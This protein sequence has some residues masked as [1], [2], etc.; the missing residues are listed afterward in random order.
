M[1]NTKKKSLLLTGLLMLSLLSGCDRQNASNQTGDGAD[2]QEDKI[3]I[4]VQYEAGR[5]N[6]SL[7]SVLEE[8]FPDVDI[9]TDELVGE[10]EYIIEKEMENHLE[11]DI[12]LYED[13]W[14][15][16]DGLMSERFYDLSQE[17]FTDRFYLSAISDCVR[18]DGGL[19][20]LPGPIYIYGIVYDKTAFRE[21]N[22]SVPKSYSEF[23]ELIQT[24][25]EMNL[26]GKEPDENNPEQLVDV[27]VAP[28][29]P[30]MKW[31]DM[32]SIVFN[33]YNYEDYL[34]GTDNTMWLADYQ[35]GKGSMVGHMEGAAD[36]F[37]QLFEDGVMSTD[38]WEICAPV[39][40]QKLYQYH[41]SLMTIECQSAIGYNKAENENNKDNM[42]EIG[43]MPFYTG[44]EKDS[45]YVYSMPRCYFGM[46]KKAAED[47]KK[48]EAILKIFEYF[49]TA[50]GQELLIEGGGGEINLLKATDTP[51][52]PFY[53]EI[54]DA[55]DEGRMISNFYYAGKNEDVE[56]YLHAAT[57]DLVKGNI[58]VKQWL[59]EA[60]NVRDKVAHHTND[61]E[62]SYGTVTRTL[63]MEE[64][65]VVIGEAYIHETGADIGIV[66]CTA[67][68]GMKFRLFEGPVTDT[69][70]NSIATTRMGAGVI[71]GD[72]GHT[73]LVVVSVTGQELLDLLNSYGDTFVATAGLDVEYAPDRPDGERYVSLKFHGKDLDPSATYTAAVVR[74]AAKEL[75]V[76]KV[77]EELTFSDMFIHYL[78]S[79]GGRISEP[80]SSLTIVK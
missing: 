76:K 22:L 17:N 79:I 53:D 18:S 45:D 78:D 59:K 4:K 21:L 72:S 44:D 43:M 77:Y 62:V 52:D 40:T 50:N 3:Q 14:K 37:L 58:S 66:P 10:S 56:A 25:N 68:F 64:T 54:R 2:T 55:V 19:Y 39:R 26:M 51:D 69:V 12:Y 24:V 46:T 41:T 65:A 75:P 1:R 67:S 27:K 35:E 28:F 48:K 29:V 47:E 13:L 49:S 16:D 36:N 38:F 15:M 31:P 11:P 8:K 7:E 9:V 42:H 80:P 71:A 61:E 57:P 23:V 74:G 30:T 32:W 70:I 60:D 6:L 5:M 33:T 63:T 34:R 73:Q 20:Y